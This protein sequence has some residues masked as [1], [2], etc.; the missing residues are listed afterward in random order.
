MAL[1]ERFYRRT[2]QVDRLD[3]A[4]A[5]S[6]LNSS[7]YFTGILGEPVRDNSGFLFPGEDGFL[8]SLKVSYEVDNKFLGKIYA[9]VVDGKVAAGS[10]NCSS[11]K[12]ELCYSG[13]ILK[14]SPFFKRSRRKGIEQTG[15]LVQSLNQ[16]Q[17]IL[18][19]CKNLDTEFLQVFF[20]S[21]QGVWRIRIR[22]YG[23]SVVVLMFPPMRYK[24]ML[25]KGHAKEMYAVLKAIASVIQKL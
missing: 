22:P 13:M 20:D 23:G 19:M 9:M 16:D 5:N 14:R 21:V 1:L 3:K 12:A 11:E 7:R 10:A 17:H 18:N 25:P 6:L 2:R 8:L 15:Y 24:V 4:L